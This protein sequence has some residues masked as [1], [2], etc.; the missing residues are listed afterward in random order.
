MA[1]VATHPDVLDHILNDLLSVGGNEFLSILEN[2]FNNKKESD[3]ISTALARW[4][5]SMEQSYGDTSFAHL[6][7]SHTLN[8]ILH[9][10]Q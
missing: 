7:T 3:D 6:A 1:Y 2:Y 8:Q 5:A 9:H 4:G 10:E